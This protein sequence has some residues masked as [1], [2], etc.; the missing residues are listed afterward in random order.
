METLSAL[1]AICA[2]DSPVIGEFPSQRPETRSF[3]VFLDL[4]PNKRVNNREA[5]DLRRHRAHHDV[6]AMM[7]KTKWSMKHCKWNEM[8][9]FSEGDIEDYWG[10]TKGRPAVHQNWTTNKE[11][12]ALVSSDWYLLKN[13]GSTFTTL[14]DDVIKWKHFPR[15]WPCHLYGKFTDHTHTHTHKGQWCGGL[16]FPLICA[17]M[18]GWVNNRE[19]GDLRHHRAHYD[20][21]VM[22][23][24]AY[25][26]TA[27]ITWEQ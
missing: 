27:N 17:W 6:T 12:S 16:M 9:A 11:P 24:R 15:Y 23:C 2:R 18:T 3:D 25:T 7:M 14:H 13:R 4:R 1:L 20:V 5:G 10:V 22:D 26:C 19:A 21:T 8:W